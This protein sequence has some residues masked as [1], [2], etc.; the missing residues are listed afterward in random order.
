MDFLSILIALWV[1][2]GLGFALLLNFSPRHALWRLKLVMGLASVLPVG[3]ISGRLGAATFRAFS[4]IPELVRRL[5]HEYYLSLWNVTPYGAIVLPIFVVFCLLLALGP[6]GRSSNRKNE[7]E[8]VV[9]SQFIGGCS[10]KSS[11]DPRRGV[12]VSV[13]N[14]GSDAGLRQSVRDILQGIEKRVKADNG[15]LRQEL[16]QQ[17]DAFLLH[18]EA[19]SVTPTTDSVRR[20]ITEGLVTS[21]LSTGV[22]L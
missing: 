14:Q 6:W 18:Q 21:R 9:I 1:S 13:V 22:D 11:E 17:L 16:Q 7:R 20:Q 15:E 2:A 5:Y 10:E 12:T 19:K 8:N 3:Q 4:Q